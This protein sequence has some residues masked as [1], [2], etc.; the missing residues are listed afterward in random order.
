MALNSALHFGAPSTNRPILWHTTF[1]CKIGEEW[2][3]AFIA[4]PT[5]SGVEFVACVDSG[6]ADAIYAV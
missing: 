2:N 4:A 6:C 1:A 3:V 5:D